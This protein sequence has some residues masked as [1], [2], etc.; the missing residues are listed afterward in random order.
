VLGQV[1]A[2]NSYAT[3]RFKNSNNF[4]VWP[5]S[6]IKISR[7]KLPKD[8][9]KCKS[10]TARDRPKIFKM[11]YIL[12]RVNLLME[13]KLQLTYN[14]AADKLIIRRWKKEKGI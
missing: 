5:G 2:G 1:N 11:T 6:A 3:L 12:V 8:V 10:D 13:D 9:R 7:R 4:K 14:N